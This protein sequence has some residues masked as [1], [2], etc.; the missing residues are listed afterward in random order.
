MT[1]KRYAVIDVETTG[2]SART[3]KITEI[4]IVLL[5]NDKIVDSYQTLIHPERPIPYGIT[6]LTGI[7]NAMVA[8]APKFYEVAKK[9]IELTEDRIFVAHNVHFDYS[10]VKKEFSELGFSFQ[11]KT[12]C[13]VRLAREFFPGHASYS[14]G[15]ITKDLGIVLE[16]AHRALD[17]ARASADILRM[18]LSKGEPIVQEEM[19]LP[20]DLKKEQYI[21]LPESI[22][23]YQFYDQEGN[24]LYIGKSLNIKKR[25]GDHFRVKFSRKKEFEFKNR[26]ASIEYTETQS[27]LLALI[28]E[29][30]WI[31]SLKPIYNL[32]KKRSRFLYGLFFNEESE[33]F[34]VS[35]LHDISEPLLVFKS[36]KTG[37]L[38]A[39][40]F[41]EAY[42]Q[43]PQH[44][45][46]NLKLHHLFRRHSYPYTDFDARE[47]QCLFEIRDDKLKVA[48]LFD[49]ETG[50]VSQ[51]FSLHESRDEKELFLS[52]YHAQKL[53]IISNTKSTSSEDY[54][55]SW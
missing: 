42:Q 49:Q 22:G 48:R 20:P 11:R 5:D 19:A 9:I 44:F 43:L 28:L 50:E 35:K 17:D 51:S 41:Q 47:N 24:L 37:I 21:T 39:E 16:N 27:E 53:K 15:K 25:V 23:V 4:A 8:N 3:Q 36:R 12:L 52:F 40:K 54:D 29:S 13:T 45:K 38:E 32:A 34:K 1:I 6:K 10:F 7:T 30:M 55:Y 18:V 31:K 2:G 14:L 33:L 46:K 26:I